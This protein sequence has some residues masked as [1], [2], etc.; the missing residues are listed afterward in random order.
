MIKVADAFDGI[1]PQEKEIIDNFTNDL[2]SRFINDLETNKL[3]SFDD[4]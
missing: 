4:E 3:A 2:K 1:V